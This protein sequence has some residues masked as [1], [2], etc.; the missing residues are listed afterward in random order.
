MAARQPRRRTAAGR[1]GLRRLSHG[2]GRGGGKGGGRGVN[3]RIRLLRLGFMVFLILIGGRAVALATSAGNLTRIALQQQTREVV[4]PAHRGAILDANGQELAVGKPQQTVFATPYLLKHPGQ[5]ARELCA[6]LQIHK[7]R[8]RRALQAALSDHKSGFAYVARQTDPQLAQ[9][10]LHLDLPG[11]GA[12]TEEARTYPMSGSAQQVIGTTNIDNS[13]IAGLELQYNKQL[14][15]RAGSEVVVRDPAGNTLRTVRQTQPASGADVRLTIDEDIQN[16][17]E[18]VLAGTVRSSGAKSAVGIV[19]DPR[20]GDI[21]AMANVPTLKGKGFGSDPKDDANRCV[22]DVFEPGSIF[23]LVT[24][25]GALADGTVTPTTRFYCPPTL[26]L[27]DRV[28]H[29]AEVR[30]AKDY[31][32]KQIIQYS[33]NIGAVK[34][35]MRMGK[36]SMLRWMKT[37]GFGKATGIAFPGESSGIVPP[38]DQWSGSSI[39]NIPMGQ[40]IAVTPLQITEAFATVADDGVAVQPRLVSRIGT[41]MLAPS[42]RRRVVPV[43]TARQMRA[44][45]LAVVQAGTGTKA[46]IPGY[47][48]AGKTGTAEKVVNG[49]YSKT[50]FVASFI[51]MVPAAHPKLVVMVAVDE[52]HSPSYFGGDIAAP[53]VQKIMHFT[54]DHLEIAP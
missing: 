36:D 50:K 24:V 14:S 43:Q 44:M 42:P 33:S 52:P 15:G 37:F 51:G 54:L 16:T 5:A 19:M 3:G 32:V 6:A 47:Q 9:A 26:H 35:G 30:G 25:S 1:G 10:A 40:G 31:S 39:L 28:L 48:V 18:A 7:E 17:A 12:Y 53:A 45:L 46:Q 41:R 38:G 4:L 23:K 22:T 21:L 2:V 49:T 27:A 8:E 34:I 11:V 29:D 13:G 20:T